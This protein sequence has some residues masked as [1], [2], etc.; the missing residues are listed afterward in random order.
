MT[1][2]WLLAIFAVCP[3]AASGYGINTHA[4]LSRVSVD[5]SKMGDSALF[6]DWG[7]QGTASSLGFPGTDG[8]T[9]SA[10]EL[11]AR[12]VVHEDDFP[13]SLNHFFDPINSRPLV[14]CL[15]TAGQTSPQWIINGD[16]TSDPPFTFAQARK[17]MLGA[18]TSAASDDR[19]RNF[20]TLFETVG[21]VI[22]HI[23]DMAQPQHVRNDQHLDLSGLTGVADKYQALP[24]IENRSRYE[25]YTDNVAPTITDD[26]SYA[27]AHLPRIDDYWQN[28]QGSGLAQFTNA[29]FVS[30]GTN[31]RLLNGFPASGAKYTLPVPGT[32]TAANIEDEL[33][34]S[35]ACPNPSHPT[36]PG[37]SEAVC[38]LRGTL[39]FISNHL[40]DNLTGDTGLNNDRASMYSIFTQDLEQMGPLNISIKQC[41]GSFA[42][43][44]LFSVNQLTFPD[45]HK[46]LLP[47][48]IGYS[49][50]II[51]YMFRGKIDLVPH[52]LADG[53][54]APSFDFVN[55]GDEPLTGTVQLYYDDTNGNRYPVVGTG[56][57]MTVTSL[58]PA[59]PPGSLDRSNRTQAPAIPDQLQGPDT[60]GVYMIVFNGT[61]GA[62]TPIGDGPGAVVA[63]QV[64][65]P[66]PRIYFSAWD[67]TQ[68]ITDGADV[69]PGRYG[70]VVLSFAMPPDP[71][72]PGSYLFDS[73]FFNNFAAS[74]V[75]LNGQD[76]PP[77][78]SNVPPLPGTC[79]PFGMA[80]I[81][82]N[83]EGPGGGTADNTRT[84]NWSYSTKNWVS[85]DEG[86]NLFGNSDQF[87]V[88]HERFPNALP[89][90][91]TNLALIFVNPEQSM[92]VE[93]LIGTQSIFKFCIRIDPTGIPLTGGS[94]DGISGT[95]YISRM[96]G[97][98]LMDGAAGI[99]KDPNPT[100]CPGS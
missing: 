5:R 70:Q 28:A 20:G 8:Q 76:Y 85:W 33:F 55:L 17:S 74:H 75:K 83:I 30:E 49:A 65:L 41:D 24:W 7:M 81:I 96:R 94:V 100:S 15:I 57:P 80:P 87:K 84:W 29:N 36:I 13:R 11:V 51:D 42:V 98:G 34:A 63:K 44:G 26:G 60:P 4:Q 21:H 38:S 82:P 68:T 22:H 72:Q 52:V 45:A 97:V 58:A 31:F 89:A 69:P 54:T 6:K 9:N 19:K 1:K 53:S 25:E 86:T 27:N 90:C 92:S 79:T 48:A 12:G 62:E 23:E 77:P 95:A 91:A 18:F 66:L 73:F 40:I 32:E 50:G 99:F 64:T 10:R 43:G 88:I 2:A 61:M 46:F 16:Q 71:S 47:R 37:H 39:I 3:L 78:A 35:G 56:W 59:P 93:Y 67:V 14:S